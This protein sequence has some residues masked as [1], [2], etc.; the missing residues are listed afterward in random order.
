VLENQALKI[1][2]LNAFSHW[3]EGLQDYLAGRA[4]SATL[5]SA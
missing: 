3:K 4:Q 1:K 2:S 5:V